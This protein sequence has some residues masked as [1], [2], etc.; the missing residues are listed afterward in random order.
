MRKD[1]FSY[2][3][4]LIA[5]ALLL[6]ACP[7]P[8][9]GE[10]M[11]TFSISLGSG[12]NSRAIY[13]P[14][15]ADKDSPAISTLTFRAVFTSENAEPIAFTSSGNDRISG[16]IATGTYTVTVSIFYSSGALYAR[17]STT[18]TVVS[19]S[20]AI[21][22]AVHKVLSIKFLHINFMDIGGGDF[23]LSLSPIESLTIGIALSGFI[24][25]VDANKVHLGISAGPGLTISGHDAD[26]NATNGAKAFT[27]KIEYDGTTV[28]ENGWTEFT[29]TGFDNLPTNTAYTYSPWPSM[30]SEI[31]RV[32]DGVTVELERTIFVTQKNIERFNAYAN[33]P[34]GL[35]KHYWLMEPIDLNGITWTP[36]GSDDYPFTGSF[37][38]GCW[39]IKNLTI[40]STT[41]YQGMFGYMDGGAVRNL[42]LVDCDITGSLYVGGIAGH[43]INGLIENCYVTGSVE[44]TSQI[45]GGIVGFNRTLGTDTAAIIRNC[46]TTADITGGGISV[47][48]I[49]GVNGYD[50]PDAYTSSVNHIV[51]NCYA[52]G[53]INGL[54]FVGGIVG[55]NI[56]S[57]T[58]QNCVALNSNIEYTGNLDSDKY[59]G[60]VAGRGPTS[61]STLLNNY[62]REPM[63]FNGA[64]GTA[65][66]D[67]I[68]GENGEDITAV[69]Y[70][71][72]TWWRNSANWDI[73]NSA[74]VLGDFYVEGIW[75]WNNNTNLPI[76]SGFKTEQNHE[77]QE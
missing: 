15:T 44:G 35:D 13:P 10:E 7:G 34:A 28:L 27:L 1:I 59:Y 22:V 26:G 43:N 20:N 70:N 5:C 16:S 47:G 41:N 21:T 19:G 12:G 48:G 24:N 69:E 62:G 63:N 77:V 6:A 74:A 42:G 75:D 54:N 52:T 67:A 72:F 55:Q 46:Y 30:S 36:I 65:W 64:P 4:L 8:D 3:L 71:T 51:E 14:G 31:I 29:Y 49:V 23:S 18:Y 2:S 40:N 57:I 66:T 76:L 68:Y 58:I 38:G 39:T 37:D 45:V 56:G 11:A 32:N 73:T 53:A 50:G 61:L 17:G 33:T 25:D 60:R 9:A